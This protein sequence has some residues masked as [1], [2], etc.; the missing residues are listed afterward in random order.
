[1]SKNLPGNGLWGWLGRQFGYVRTAVKGN[2]TQRVIYRNQDKKEM[3]MPGA[4][5]VTLRRTV[6]D[7]VVVQPKKLENKE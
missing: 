5:G 3:P 1:M 7:E 6:I 2:V 4:P